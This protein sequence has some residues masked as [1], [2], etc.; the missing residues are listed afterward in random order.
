MLNQYFKGIN[1]S[2]GITNLKKTKAD[3]NDLDHIDFSANNIK[4]ERQ[5]CSIEKLEGCFV[6]LGS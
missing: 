5:V 2:I 3:N 1:L 4:Y 6:F